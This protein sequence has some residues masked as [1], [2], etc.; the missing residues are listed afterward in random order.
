MYTRFFC[1]R[2]SIDGLVTQSAHLIHAVVGRRIQ[3]QHIQNGTVFNAKAGRAKITRV[4][5]YRVFAVDCPGQQLGAGSFSGAAGPC[6][7]ICVRKAVGVH[8]AFERFGNMNL[9]HNIIK[10][11]GA[12]FTVKGLIQKPTPHK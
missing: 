5:P 4:T 12:P 8:L 11:A 6:K 3:F 2:W 7:Q 9:A 10:R 1:R